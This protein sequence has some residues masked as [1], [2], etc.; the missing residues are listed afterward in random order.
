LEKLKEAFN[1][2]SVNRLAELLAAAH[3]NFPARDFSRR[4][5]RTLPQLELKDRVRLI[6]KAIA[7]FLPPEPVRALPILE[8]VIKTENHP[9]GV[10]GFQAWPLTQVVEDIAITE[11]ELALATLQKLTTV[12]SA[13]FAIRP[14][15][16]EH[17][18][19][20]LSTLKKWARDPNVHVRRLVSEG[21]RPRLPWGQRIPVF[22][23]D[24][25][26]CLPLLKI[27]RRDPEIY[28]RKSVANHLND[29]SKDHPDWL[30][31]EL[32]T[33][34]SEYPECP[35]ISWIVRHACR[36]LIKAGH[37][38]ALQLQGFSP[39]KVENVRLKVS[40]A[41]V[42]MGGEI[43]VNFSAKAARSEAWLVDYAVH[44]RKKNGE[45]KPKVFKWTKAT[46]KAGEKISL[47][48]RHRFVEI[49][50]R[51]YYAGIHEVEVFVN[52]QTVGKKPFLLEMKSKRRGK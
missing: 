39:A 35:R 28:V 44:H 11:P 1:A 21:T 7:E 4:I 41:K 16:I 50:T 37:P 43:T 40:P 32:A 49:S 47:E 24:P 18:R 8:A 17:Q 51:E 20:T 30:V 25:S 48:K 2:E 42:K 14:F 22:Q 36:S 31:Q 45:T 13:E 5:L 6:A 46:P 3:P 34:I 19:L 23:K 10:A 38:A 12:M 27:L 9:R 52:G 33:W 26:I 15:L 29:F